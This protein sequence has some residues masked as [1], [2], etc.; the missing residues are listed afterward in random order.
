MYMAV[1]LPTPP[2]PLPTLCS[3]LLLSTSPY[4][5]QPSVTHVYMAVADEGLVIEG[6]CH[7]LPWYARCSPPPSTDTMNTPE[8]GLSTH[9]EVRSGRTS[10]GDPLR[11]T[12]FV[13]EHRS[14]AENPLPG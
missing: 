8:S 1:T 7:T 2:F 9:A 13:S 11:R 12:Y 10:D 6:W 3:A 5:G 14:Q 4:P